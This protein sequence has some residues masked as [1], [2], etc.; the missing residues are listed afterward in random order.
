MIFCAT[1]THVDIRQAYSLHQAGRLLEAKAAYEAILEQV[2]SN[3]DAWQLLGMV[4]GQVGQSLDAAHCFE[5]AV[6]LAPGNAEAHLNLGMA[7]LQLNR[8]A[9]AILCCKRALAIK[10]D[11][12]EAYNI[13]GKLLHSQGSRDEA[14]ASYRQALSFKRDLVDACN[15]LGIALHELGE[16]EDAVASFRQALSY[17][18]DFTDALNNL[19]IALQ[20]QGKLDEAG[21]CFRKALACEAN[22]AEAHGNL[23]MVLYR[24]GKLD[25]AMGS[26]QRALSLKPD[27]GEAHSNLG[28]VL[29]EQGKPDEAV[30]SLHRA[31]SLRPDFAK[32]HYNLGKALHAQDK[33]DEAIE[34]YRRALSLKPDYAEALCNLGAV[35]K[36]Q[37]KLDEAS[38]CLHR[39]LALEPDLA[40]AHNN[41][42][43]VLKEQGRLDEA[44]AC[45][46]RALA[47]EPDL[48]IAHGNLGVILKEQGKLDE[49][50]LSLQRAISLDP[51]MGDAYCNLGIVLHK[52]GNGEAAITSYRNV[53]ARKPEFAEAHMGLA[54][55]LSDQDQIDLA[56]ESYRRAIALKPDFA[57]AYYNLLF[58]YGHQSWLAPQ[59]YLRQARGW[60]MNCLSA[61]ERQVAR[62]R[63][64]QRPPLAGRRLKVGYVSGDFFAH[65]ASNFTAPLFR[66]HDRARLEIF[67]YSNSSV[68]DAMSERLQDLADHWTTL[69]GM[70]DTAI[71]ERI[72]A[73]G[74]DV[75]ID[76]SGHTARNRLKVFALRAAPVQAHYL[77]FFASTGLTEMDYWI[78]DDILTPPETDGHFSEQVWRLPRTWVCYEGKAGAPPSSWRPAADG[79]VWLGSFNR[80]SK[81]T[82]ATLTLWA[83]VLHALPEGRLLL[84]TS[85]LADAGNRQRILD[86]F[87]NQG[88]AASRIEL[89]DHRITPSPLDHMAYYD[90]LDI[91]LDPAGA[92]GGGTTTCDALWM[93]VPVVALIGDRMASRMTASMLNAVGH[94]EWIARSE[95]EYIEKIVALARN[96]DH[97]KDLRLT[98]R[99]EM[100]RS[101]LCDARDLA[102]KLENAYCEMFERWFDLKNDRV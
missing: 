62:S 20:E 15:N 39:A 40:V 1:K 88:V 81:L 24:Q 83:G 54:N 21:A 42:G 87:V 10:P 58:V 17:W 70:S 38:A 48:A 98:L 91:A 33:R 31:I 18:P 63:A 29:L 73:D 99:G 2:P 13:L 69:V 37:G 22:F 66:H 102:T 97:R 86:A 25:E 68:R 53:L 85:A 94:P 100:S 93:A 8:Q 52:L 12:A 57:D 27:D 43:A 56:I 76:L 4:H 35:L 64:F 28:I 5:K 79:S 47:L 65:A 75:L 26:L 3:F 7:L 71:R 6:A 59:E 95:A 14:V 61:L 46:H 50:V 82:P 55:I 67:A 90:R 80:L 34:S 16:L 96:V 44:S 89:Q 32:A 30:V 45:V 41:L 23:G 78:G 11:F 51:D 74:I 60:E 49:A 36:E 101:P 9:D 92:V 84:K 72:E 77:G 19:G